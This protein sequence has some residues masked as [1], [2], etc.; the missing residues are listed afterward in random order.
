[1][2]HVAA[3][4]PG[5]PDASHDASLAA[6]IFAVDPAAIGGVLVRGRLS[7][8]REAWQDLVLSCLPPSMPCRRIPAGIDDER[9]LGG[10]DLSATLAAGRPMSAKGVLALAHGGIVLLPQG[11]R[12]SRA[13]AARIAAVHDYSVITTNRDGAVVS[14]P[15][16]FGVLAFDEGVDADERLALVLAD[17]LAV[18]IDLDRA[19]VTTANFAPAADALAR[20]AQARS[21]VRSVTAPDA[22]LDALAATAVVLGVRSDRALSLA[23]AVAR[24]AAALDGSNTVRD[25]DVACAARLVL[26]PRATR[27]PSQAETY[28]LPPSRRHLKRRTT[29][30][31]SASRR[32]MSCAI[33]LSRRRSRLYQR[34]C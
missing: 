11:E 18:H 15:A 34:I 27:V 14:D 24:T 25:V 16:R 7:P 32:T 33:S 4:P 23:L 3:Q 10:L 12:M 21:A 2:M 26:A 20:I 5:R 28:H 22:A 1:M 29:R 9:L 31:R 13:L 6:L 8:V 17:R 19:D 30:R